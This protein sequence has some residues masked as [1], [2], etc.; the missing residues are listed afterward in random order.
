[1]ES[2][3]EYFE[4]MP[5]WQKLAWILI[6]LSFNWIGEAIKPLVK[7]NYK[8][9]KHIGVNMIFLASDL[10]INVLFGLATVGIMAWLTTNQVGLLYM[11]DL[12]FLL[13]LLIAVM[14]LDFFAQYLAHY[15]LHNIPFMWRFHMI[16]HSDT[17]VDATTATRH[18]PGDYVMR[19]VF[20][21]FA[22]VLGGIPFAFYIFYR[23]LTIFFAYFSHANI[24]LPKGLDRVLGYIIVTPDMHKFHHHFERPWTDTNFGNIFSFWDRLLGTLVYEN[25]DDITY[26]LDVADDSRDQD[27]GY[28]F[29]L[30]FNKSIKVESRGWKFWQKSE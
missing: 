2:F 18:H 21:L 4:T 16:H 20:A 15:L 13:E 25:T 9:L 26:G 28:Q 6:C 11:V 12:P 19:E 7:F 22:I 30:P 10:T 29:A 3:M 14:M 23:V 24:S 8:K 17:H 27:I 5:S 1:M